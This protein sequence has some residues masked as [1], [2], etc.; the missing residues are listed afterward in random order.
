MFIQRVETG[1]VGEPDGFL[2]FGWTGAYDRL[3]KPVAR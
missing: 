2:D 1:C 3:E